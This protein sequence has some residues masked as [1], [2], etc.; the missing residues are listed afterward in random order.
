MPLV[1]VTYIYNWIDPALLENKA[2]Y[3]KNSKAIIT[4]GRIEE[5]KGIPYIIEIAEKVFRSH[6]TWVWDIFGGGESEYIETVQKSLK[7]KG[8]ENKVRLRGVDKNI[9]EKYKDYS[10][11][12]M[13]SLTEG[14]P[15]VL[16]EAKANH[17]PIVSF[18]C[19]TGPSE[20]VQDG[21]NGYLIPL[22]D[23]EQFA[24]KLDKLMSSPDL[25][26]DFSNHAMDNGGRFQKEKILSQWIS[27]IKE[28]TD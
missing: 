16:L 23:S 12:A 5:L 11:F 14:L 21:I 24:D 4:V 19:K 9:L 3:N 1:K 20:I 26:Q 15:M 7:D 17:L 22:K 27:L 10:L 28:L 6:P 8:L 13:A 25:R 2:S 18:N